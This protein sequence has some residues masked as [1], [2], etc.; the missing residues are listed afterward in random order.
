[1]AKVVNTYDVPRLDS[2]HDSRYRY[3][4]VQPHVLGLQNM[5]GETV[6]YPPGSAGASRYHEGTEHLFDSTEGRGTLSVNDVPRQVKGGRP[7]GLG[8]AGEQV[9]VGGGRP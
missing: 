6:V 5:R 8:Y 4:T 2:K 1:M 7:D 3:E 9:N